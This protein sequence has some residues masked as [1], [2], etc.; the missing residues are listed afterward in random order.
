M[1]IPLWSGYSNKDE[2]NLFHAS[3]ML[4]ILRNKRLNVFQE[5]N[6]KNKAVLSTM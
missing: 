3:S 1:N 5:R 6:K 4:L 2:T